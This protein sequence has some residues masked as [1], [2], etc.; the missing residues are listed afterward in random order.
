[1][2]KVQVKDTEN[3]FVWVRLVKMGYP[4]A[5]VSGFKK[6]ESALNRIRKT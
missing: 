3:I 6:G 1:M 2:T 5:S 4:G